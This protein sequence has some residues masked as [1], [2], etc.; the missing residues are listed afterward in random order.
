MLELAGGLFSTHRL[1]LRLLEPQSG[2]EV[3][4]EPKEG[5]VVPIP[6]SIA[7]ETLVRFVL[8]LIAVHSDR[9]S[10][11]VFEEP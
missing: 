1:K 5:I 6:L 8:H 11:L 2:I 4:L 3:Q 10:V 7:S 9:D